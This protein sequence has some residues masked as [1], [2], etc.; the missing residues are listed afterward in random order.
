M[1]QS[2]EQNHEQK[3]QV[4]RKEVEKESQ[5]RL[6]LGVFLMNKLGWLKTGRVRISF[7]EKE[8]HRSKLMPQF[9]LEHYN[10]FT[11]AGI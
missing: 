1:C 6:F 8:I 7:Q 11:V 4:Y 3:P 5:Q 2:L 10:E 9:Y